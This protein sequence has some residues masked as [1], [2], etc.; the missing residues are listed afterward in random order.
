MYIV[1]Y[2]PQNENEVKM[3]YLKVLSPNN[4]KQICE[5]IISPYIYNY[6]RNDLADVP[7]EKR[8]AA[9]YYL[10]FAGILEKTKWSFALK[11]RDS[12]LLVL[13]KA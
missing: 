9:K 13:E 7:I 11:L 5:V 1:K 8:D 2:I 10:C 3:Y 6:L 12:R 4:K